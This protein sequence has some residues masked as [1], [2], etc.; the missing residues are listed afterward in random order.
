[1]RL[2][3]LMTGKKAGVLNFDRD[4]LAQVGEGKHGSGEG[5]R[6]LWDQKG[7]N[8]V[9][10]FERGAAVFGI[11]SKPKA[12]IRP[13][14]SMKLHQMRFMPQT[15]D[16]NME[17]VLAVSSEDG[18]ILF[19][20]VLVAQREPGV[21]KMPSCTCIA[22]LGGATAGIS[23]RIKDFEI[24]PL[25]TVSPDEK[26]PLLAVTA[27]SDG[28][29]RLWAVSKDELG[30]S[31]DQQANGGERASAELNG[32]DEPVR[33]I[34][35]LIGTLETGNRITCLATFIMDTNAGRDVDV[36][37][38]SMPGAEG[39]DDGSENESSGDSDG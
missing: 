13:S 20:D 11:D 9:V 38:D 3:N 23:G 15:E 30:S 29:I 14:R 4:L 17:D 33:Q 28:A 2:W 26:A 34:G 7:E 31:L 8:F 32:F 6:V 37:S 10:G 21:Q 12:V 1:M 39:G 27:N 35:R 5:R 36:I 18:R 16:S 19:F 24:L 22:E 25:S